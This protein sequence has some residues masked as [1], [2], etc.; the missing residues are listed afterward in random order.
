LTECSIVDVIGVI[1]DIHSNR[2][3]GNSAVKV[4]LND[5]RYQ[6]VTTDKNVHFWSLFSLLFV[7]LIVYFLRGTCECILV[8]NYADKIKTLMSGLGSDAPILLLQSVQIR[9]KGG[10][11]NVLFSYLL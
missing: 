9:N 8:G 1:R 10:L 4:T 3:R 7:R 2:S 6:F 5:M 11:L